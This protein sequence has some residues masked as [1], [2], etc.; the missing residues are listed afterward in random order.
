MKWT[1]ERW[2]QEAC[3]LDEIVKTMQPFDPAKFRLEH[4]RDFY[5]QQAAKLEKERN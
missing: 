1:A 4:E 2:F 3:E 5:L